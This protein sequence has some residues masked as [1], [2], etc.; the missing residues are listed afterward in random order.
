MGGRNNLLPVYVLM[1]LLEEIQAPSQ[2]Q[3]LPSVRLCHLGKL[4]WLL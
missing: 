2:K 4:I 3:I 1:L